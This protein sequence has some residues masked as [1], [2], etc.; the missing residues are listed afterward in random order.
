VG[1]DIVLGTP[2]PGELPVEELTN[3]FARAKAEASAE[4]SE[5]PEPTWVA[6]AIKGKSALTAATVV[7]S[8]TLRKVLVVIVEQGPMTAISARFGFGTD[9]MGSPPVARR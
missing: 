3:S 7:S 5:A 1:T 4:A 8:F 9:G 2:G 6:P